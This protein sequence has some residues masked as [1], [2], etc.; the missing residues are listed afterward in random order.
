MIELV[1]KMRKYNWCSMMVENS[2]RQC[3]NLY[4]RITMCRTP[5]QLMDR[6]QV[7]DNTPQGH[8]YWVSVSN[9]LYGR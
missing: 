1:N 8:R 5:R 9:D 4:D 7:W 6:S 2:K 3:T